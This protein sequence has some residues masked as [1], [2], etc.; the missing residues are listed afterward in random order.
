MESLSAR[1]LDRLSSG[2]A[3]LIAYRLS[4]LLAL[5]A[6]CTAP[7]QLPVAG[8]PQVSSSRLLCANMVKRDEEEGK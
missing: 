7:G 2:G 5:A 3:L 6:V 8:F 4:L 1:A